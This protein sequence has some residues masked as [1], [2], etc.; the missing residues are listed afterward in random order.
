MT[1]I[2]E[3]TNY[4]NFA[5][6][7]INSFNLNH[8]FEYE[9]LLQLIENHNTINNQLITYFGKLEKIIKQYE[10]KPKETYGKLLQKLYNLRDDIDAID[11]ANKDIIRGLNQKLVEMGTKES[12][13][14]DASIEDSNSPTHIFLFICH[15]KEYNVSGQRNYYPFQHDLFDSIGIISEYGLTANG[16]DLRDKLTLTENIHEVLNCP[17]VNININQ[18]GQSFVAINPLS[19]S[20]RYDDENNEYL[21]PYMGL[22]YIKAQ[23][24]ENNET[25]L[26]KMEHI[27][28][29]ANKIPLNK[30]PNQ[31]LIHI[32]ENEQ[33]KY[34][35][36]DI[37]DSH[38]YGSIQDHFG[39]NE[40][41]GWDRV[42][43]L[44]SRFYKAGLDID[45]GDRKL[46]RE[47][48]E[49][50]IRMYT[51]RG[52]ERKTTG[53]K[54]KKSSP[55]TQMD[56]VLYDSIP[57]EYKNEHIVRSFNLDS[58]NI[59]NLNR[60]IP[61]FQ[62]FINDFVTMAGISVNI[63]VLFIYLLT[64]IDKDIRYVTQAQK[65]N[66]HKL[67]ERL[68]T[69]FSDVGEQSLEQLFV[70]LT[71]NKEGVHEYK[72]KKL[73]ISEFSVSEYSTEETELL[74]FLVYLLQNDLSRVI[75]N[76]NVMNGIKIYFLGNNVVPSVLFIFFQNN[77]AHVSLEYIYAQEQQYVYNHQETEPVNFADVFISI[78]KILQ[79]NFTSIKIIYS[80]NILKG[81]MN[82]YGMP[83]ERKLKERKKPSKYIQP[84]NS[85][86]VEENKKL[87]ERDKQLQQIY[88]NPPNIFQFNTSVSKPNSPISLKKPDEK[89]TDSQPL[90]DI[91]SITPGSTPRFTDAA[92]ISPDIT[93]NRTMTAPGSGYTDTEISPGHITR[94][95]PKRS[96]SP[97]TSTSRV[98]KGLTYADSELPVSNISSPKSYEDL[99]K[100][101][102]IEEIEAIKAL[103]A[104]KAQEMTTSVESLPGNK[105]D[106][107]SEEGNTQKEDFGGKK[108]GKKGKKTKRA[109][110]IKKM[111]KARKTKKKR[112]NK[113]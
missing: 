54:G 38:G 95:R 89:Q 25:R 60:N 24:L 71:S 42:L 106:S 70:M 88:N 72:L 112:S 102:E 48:E 103:E 67:V 3:I 90:T 28:S 45:D 16:D 46:I 13:S 18:G 15:G 40:D 5:T 17:D 49:V 12:A 74:Q 91:D 2:Q 1:I 43:N 86:I 101:E 113:K 53:K 99:M 32:D 26:L 9:A 73:D 94:G 69:I 39:N 36:H 77:Q 59:V 85:I 61:I 22:F 68:I 107:D 34:T 30:I 79:D 82:Q 21:A 52:E 78:T 20:F 50:H 23:Q 4:I 65:L 104:L 100:L 29:F 58:E 108:K 41:F 105:T 19:L 56:Y 57:I 111:K 14:S 75:A 96:V 63:N 33:H 37:D 81:G 93:P 44:I 35:L 87:T 84:E 98:N 6:P 51:C 66:V 80:N 27:V 55:E 10:G 31:D 110:K 83:L 47:G 62:T 97:S 11:Y 64:L 76:L 92:Y 8:D 109:K 7:I